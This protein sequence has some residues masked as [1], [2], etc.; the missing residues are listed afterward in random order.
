ME[1]LLPQNVEAE[2]GVLG[3]LLID[4]EASS[5]IVGFLRADDFYR[6]AH[7]LIY[8]AILRLFDQHEPADF[9]TVCHELERQNKLEEAGGEDYIISLINRVPT[10]GNAEFYAHIV[11]QMALLRRL[12]HAGGQ[13][14]A[15][16]YGEEDAEAALDQ[17]EQF[18]FT[19]RQGYA[20]KRSQSPHIRDVITNYMERLSSLSERRDG[21]VGVPTGFLDLDRI[22]GGLQASDLIILAARPAVGKTSFALSLAYNAALDH[23]RTVG[24]FSLEMSQDQ[25]VQRLISM[26]AKIDQQRLR[27]GDLY[28]DDWERLEIS[29]TNLSSTTILIDDTPGVT[30]TQLSSKAR[31]WLTDF[32]SLDLI[33][34]DYLQLMQPPAS[35][36]RSDNRVQVIDDISRQLKALARELNVPVIALAQLSRAVES[37]QSKIPMLS[38]LRESGGLEQNADIVLFIYRDEVYNPDTERKGLADIIIAKHRNGPTGEVCLAFNRSQT[39]FHDFDTSTAPSSVDNL[40]SRALTYEG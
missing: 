35:E 16:A 26:D 3:S 14:V 40:E 38:D 22:L 9:V 39:R 8:E 37:R 20:H 33:I 30:V 13:I 27:T 11:E 25:L 2:A 24:I 23:K 15:T 5:L 6:D 4:P 29:M 19:I 10:S 21:L 28:D 7:R 17:A 1:R 12:I 31:Q 32:D 34:I 18:L 36:K